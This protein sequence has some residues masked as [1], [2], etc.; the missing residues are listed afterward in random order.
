MFGAVSGGVYY[1]CRHLRNQR[2]PG[3][4]S[5]GMA[6]AIHSLRAHVCMLSRAIERAEEREK[7]G[8]REKDNDISA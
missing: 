7:G 6:S 1:G 8:E 2:L 5:V 3:R 4:G